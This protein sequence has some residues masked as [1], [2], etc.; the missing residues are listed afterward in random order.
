[1]TC[2][3]EQGVEYLCRGLP[4]LFYHMYQRARGFDMG[5]KE[6]IVCVIDLVIQ[7]PQEVATKWLHWG[8]A[9]R[10]SSSV[11]RLARQLVFY[12]IRLF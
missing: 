8:N 3:A 2:S 6:G 11:V 7:C 10:I 4:P 12:Q 9:D 1:M 5:K